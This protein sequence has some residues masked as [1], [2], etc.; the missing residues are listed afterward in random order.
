MGNMRYLS[1]IRNSQITNRGMKM[2]NY[3]PIEMTKKEFN[4]LPHLNVALSKV[5]QRK[6]AK[7][8]GYYDK[9]SEGLLLECVESNPE[10][11]VIQPIIVKFI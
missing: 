6:H 10:R 11:I 1:N 2:R 3:T 7:R 5:G 4:S 9:A 8:K